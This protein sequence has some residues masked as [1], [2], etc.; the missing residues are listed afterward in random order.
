MVVLA[1]ILSASTSCECILGVNRRKH[2]YCHIIARIR[3][4]CANVQSSLASLGEG[5][6]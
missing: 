1:H 6:P 5:S 4:L 2:S 3:F